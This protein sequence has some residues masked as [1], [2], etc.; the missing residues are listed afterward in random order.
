MTVPV[1]VEKMGGKGATASASAENGK[2]R[3]GVGIADLDSNA[4][5]Q[6]Q[7]PS[8]VQG[9]V[10]AKVVPGSPADNAGL[11]PGD[12]IESVNRKA[13]PSASAVKDALGSVTNG[14]SVMLRVWSNGGSTFRVLHPSEG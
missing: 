4:R 9:A 12:V 7:T 6:L 2:P 1:T 13:T 10:V 11:R 8:Q 5:Q 14:D 3:W